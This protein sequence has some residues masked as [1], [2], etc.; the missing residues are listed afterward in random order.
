MQKPLCFADKFVEYLPPK[1][2]V[3]LCAIARA[4]VKPGKGILAADETVEAMD[5]LFESV[6]VP[7]TEENRRQYRQALFT[8][9]EE[10]ADSISGVIMFHETFYQADGDGKPFVEILS[11]AGIVP[12]IQADTGRVPLAGTLEELTTE[13]LD[14]LAQRFQAYKSAGAFFAKWRCS[15]RVSEDTPT[16][17]AMETNANVLARFAAICQQNGLV[18]VVELEILPDGDHDLST[19]QRATE[20]ALAFLY[21]ALS[22]HHVLVEGTLLTTSVV[23]AGQGCKT[24]YKSR[25]VAVATIE[26]LSRSVPPAVPGIGLLSGSQSERE[27]TA[28]LESINR[29]SASL[30]WALTFCFGRA[31]QTS[32][33]ARWAE[34]PEDASLAQEELLRRAQA[35]S[36]ACRPA[37]HPEEPSQFNGVDGLESEDEEEDDAAARR[38]PCSACARRRMEDIVK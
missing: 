38:G 32:A 27:A 10:L 13:G 6:R 3:E 18:P 15:L 23:R 9:N 14:D 7:N 25:E 29:R 21:K 5:K 4:L 12:G 33:L 19:A 28:N 8:A 36:S 17:L 16:Y 24:K 31:L 30:P 11:E 34:N 35:N 20:E 22:D 26:A 1:Q 2:G 37:S